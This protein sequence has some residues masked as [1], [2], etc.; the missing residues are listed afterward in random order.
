MK[1]IILYNGQLFMGGIERNIVKYAQSLSKRDDI[2]IE[3]LIKE[4]NPEKNVLFKELPA[5]VKCTFIKPEKLVAFREKASKRRKNIFWKIIYS[6]LRPYERQYMKKWLKEYFSKRD[7]VGAVV[8]FDM[9]LWNYLDAVDVPV[10]GRMSY[11]LSKNDN[12][13]IERYRKRM[14]IYKKIMVISGEMKS[15][16]EE[17]YPFIKEKTVK[18]Y[19][20][21]N[22]G[23]IDKKSKDIKGLSELEKKL[24][25]NDYMIGVSRL[26]QGKGREDLVKAYKIMKEKGLKEKL[27]LLGEGKQRKELEKLIKELGLEEDV[28]LLGQKTNP[29]IW[30]KKAKLFLHTSYG[31]GF[32]NVFL[33]SMACGTPIISYD[34]P[35]GPKEILGEDSYGWLIEMGDI[36]KFA[37][38]TLEV[39]ASEEA[40]KEKKLRVKDR[41][42]KFS[43]ETSLDTFVNMV[44]SL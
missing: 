15:E 40:Y 27:Y 29:Y 26:V 17:I 30:M 36:E 3:V 44:N 42:K 41:L 20:S 9:G 19:N 18:I 14:E 21:V 32:P 34:C 22:I 39:L 33:E 37:E 16:I 4:N 1:K 38:R 10:V 43:F 25:S 5:S 24:M 35:T 23:D 31:E 6:F 8:D 28:L 2:E 12:R 7:D 11:F 13:K